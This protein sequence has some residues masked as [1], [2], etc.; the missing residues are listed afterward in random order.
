MTDRVLMISYDGGS[1][2]ASDALGNAM[3]L[4][5]NQEQW[6]PDLPDD[7]RCGHLMLPLEQLLVRTIQLPLPN[8]R[9]V[10]ADILGQELD[11]R[12]GIEPDEW[13]LV[14]KLGV[15]EAVEQQ[16]RQVAGVVF[17]LPATRKFELE[18]SDA[19][20]QVKSVRVD[21]WSRLSKHLEKHAP[22]PADASALLVCDA[23]KQGVFIGVWQSGVCYG[24]RRLTRSDR[25]DQYMVDEILRTAQAMG[26]DSDHQLVGL[27]LLDEVLLSGLLQAGLLQE[28]QGDCQA[29]AMLPDRHA[30]NLQCMGDSES[31][32]GANFR[33]GRW[34]TASGSAWLQPW[35]R[36]FSLLGLLLFV[37]LGGLVYQ[38]HTLEQQAQAY[39]QQVI[40]AFHKGL[41]DQ[42]V[43][44]D[45]MAQLK[46]AAGGGVGP[47]DTS[48]SWLR[49]L[50]SIQTVYKASPW[51]MREVEW[52]DGTVKLAG[53]ADSLQ[54]LNS[55]RQSMQQQTGAA[56]V[57]LLDTDLSG[58]K[59]N[60]RMQW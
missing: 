3:P 38:N 16:I 54:L 26:Y 47:T 57:R 13:W 58:D 46:K 56:E 9:L 12:A 23:D 28:W 59:V 10:D 1:W 39:Q 25:S 42:K 29:T 11:D 43:M 22:A 32:P 37:W 19:W 52:R 5:H 18:S 33:H 2:Q 8:P 45:P 30:A 4:P 60:F 14:W 27:G 17:G 21:G 44:I 51:D 50:A 49:Q 24:L 55:I 34:A 40:E 41:P 20:Q 31:L 15:V 53:K 48:V 36:S 7:N 35:K 6:L